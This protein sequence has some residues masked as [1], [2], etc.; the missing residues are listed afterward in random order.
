MTMKRYIWMFLLALAGIF[1]VHA[2]A[3]LSMDNFKIKPG[4]EK[5]I[6]IKMTNTVPI[7]ALQVQVTLPECLTLVARPAIVPERQGSYIDDFGETVSA[8]KALNYNKLND[9]GY[10][11]T[12][13]ADD[14]VPFAGNEGSIIT[15]KVKADESAALKESA[16]TLQ[17]IE[18]VYEDGETYIRPSQSTCTV[19]VY[20]LFTI[21]ATASEGG[22]IAGG[23]SYDRY[24][25]G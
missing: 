20:Q 19:T 23:G 4:E 14:G 15:M 11:I 7:R 24:S 17:N 8:V 12:V 1:N 13:N 10:M 22:T 21:E 5:E 2:Q 6:A 25:F 16:I 3:T 9:G 18:L